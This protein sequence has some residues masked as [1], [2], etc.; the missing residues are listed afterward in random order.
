MEATF[1]GDLKNHFFT[2]YWQQAYPIGLY[3]VR[4]SIICIA[5]LFCLL[6][7][8]VSLLFDYMER[9]VDLLLEEK[10]N[11][12]AIR[13]PPMK[14]I[15]KILNWKNHH[16]LVCQLVDRINDCFELHILC[17][18]TLGVLRNL[19][20]IFFL[21]RSIFGSMPTNAIYIFFLFSNSVIEISQL[22]LTVYICS[23]LQTK[24]FL[25]F[26]M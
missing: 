13:A 3:F 24:V 10:C 22:Y 20:Y 21:I 9:Q 15:D 25:A 6:V 7:S 2:E 4:L 18:L 8:T 14:F 19:I 26:H 23:H 5:V 1:N 16:L 17:S 11:G 12:N